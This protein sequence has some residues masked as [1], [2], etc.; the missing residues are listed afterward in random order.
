MSPSNT[1][2]GLCASA[3]PSGRL[4]TRRA[5]ILA[6]SLTLMLAARVQAQN[7]TVS[8]RVTHA[9]DGRPAASA[10]VEARIGSRVVTRTLT[11]P[12]GRYRMPDLRPGSYVLAAHL[13]AL[14]GR[15]SAQVTIVSDSNAVVDLVLGA[16]ALAGVDVVVVTPSR[17]SGTLLDEPQMLTVVDRAE[18][19]ATVAVSPAEYVRAATGIDII[20]QGVQSTNVVARGFNNVFS[21]ALHVLTDHRNAGVPSLRVNLMHFMPQTSE[22]VERVEVVLGPGSALYGPNTANGVLHVITRSPIDDPGTSVAMTA[23]QRDV[24]IG[25]ARAAHRFSPRLGV[26]LSGQYMRGREWPYTDSVEADRRQLEILNGRPDT[27]IGD[28][29][30]DI[31][32]WSADARVDW[33]PADDAAAIL[34]AGRMV[35]V[36]GIELTGIGAAQ[37]RDWTNTYV[38]ARGHYGRLLAQAYV[39]GSDAGETFLLRD[40]NDIV[41][42]S[43]VFVAQLQH[44]F[45]PGGRHDLI[46]GAD[47]VRTVPVTD[48]TINGSNEDRDDMNEVGAYA[49]L[50]AAL[51]SRVD[52][53]MAAR[54]DRHSELP[55]AVFSPRAAI[56]FHP[57]P[58][59]TLRLTYNR[60]FSTPTALNLFLDIPA[61][62]LPDPTL[63]ALGYNIRARA[64]GRTGF[65]FRAGDPSALYIRSPFNPA[66]AGQLLEGSAT[67]LLQ[68]A[69]GV[70]Q[71]Q[72]RIDAATAALLRSLTPSNTQVGVLLLDLANPRAAAVPQEQVH[73]PDVPGIRESINNTLE[74]GYTAVVG[75]RVLLNA[76]LWYSRITNFTSPLIPQGGYLAFLDGPKLGAFLTEEL[77]R[78]GVPPQQAANQAAVLA[79]GIAALPL[80]ISTSPDIPASS[81]EM[82]VT[83]RNFGEVR[84]GG[85]DVSVEA[86]L[87]ADWSAVASAS[88]VSDDHFETEGQVIALNAPRRKATLGLGYARPGGLAADARL[89]TI[90]GFPANSAGFVGL[91]CVIGPGSGKCVEPATLLDLTLGHPLPNVPGATVQLGVQNLLN[92]GYR[93]FVGVPEIGRMALLRLRYQL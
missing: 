30:F 42:R 44:G 74:A 66:G 88:F 83:F 91:E 47:Y 82:L 10:E 32:R 16:V 68:L 77:I 52:L 37:A 24:R 7:G 13:G 43:K 21:G 18:V 85:L 40:G 46:Y 22:D 5:G 38:Q 19:E 20:T 90:A 4:R 56:L 57:T 8:G 87:S 86:K 23:G 62:P 45:S 93:S 53:L 41:D 58:Q 60:A 25:A 92:S 12:D 11:G 35:A 39:N 2:S 81:A 36:S 64:P 9:S 63:A 50:R 79:N 72:G 1:R 71:Q 29:D 33:R 75:G 27:R 54:I 67:T 84:L 14:A 76:A 80:G 15:D 17:T 89:R 73:L 49:Q 48:G 3:P 78:V 34:S 51:S 65:R 70:L 26:K 6:F 28:R 59:Q 55:E 31:E 69:A 61:G